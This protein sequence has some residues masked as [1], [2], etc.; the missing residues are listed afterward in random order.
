MDIRV[1]GKRA[2][3]LIDTGCTHSL[4]CKKVVEAK[5]I[6]Q[7]SKTILSADAKR[8]KIDGEV[9]VIVEINGNRLE[10]K[11][12]VIEKLVPG[13]D[14]IVGT[15]ILKYFRFELHYGKANI[16]ATGV[17][18]EPQKDVKEISRK[19]YKVS[20]NGKMWVAKWDWNETPR[21][22]NNIA[23]YKMKDTVSEAFQSEVQRWIENG[24][25]VESNSHFTGVV[26]LMAVV[27]ERKQKV[28]PVLDFRELNNFVNCSGVDADVCQEKLRKWRQ[29]PANC[30]MVDLRDAYMQIGVHPSCS[31][32]QIVSFN[33]KVYELKRLGFGLNCAPEIMKAIVSGVLTLDKKIAAATDHYYDD[34]IVNLD[35]VSV[36]DVIAFLKSNG[37]VCKPP[38]NIDESCVLGLQLYKVK[39]VLKWK[40]S[41][42]MD[43]NIE[44]FMSKRNVFSVCGKII[45]HYSVAGYLRVATSYIKRLCQGCTW[46]DFAG[47]EAIQK[48]KNLLDRLRRNDPVSGTWSVPTGGS[49]N[50][51]CDASKIAFGVVVEK[52]GEVVEDATWLRKEDDGSHINLAELNAIVKGTNLAL[53]WGAKELTVLTDSATVHSW[54]S[55]LLTK[56]R[57]IRV[58]GMSEMLV[59]RRLA[60][61]DETMESYSVVWSVKLISSQSNKADSLT[62]IPKEWLSR[63]THISSAVIP[64][65]SSSDHQKLLQTIT[66]IH[67]M[68]HRGIDVTQ[69][70][71]S[72]VIPNVTADAVKSVVERCDICKSVDPHPR[73]WDKGE[74]SVDHDWDR[75]ATD[76]THT[77]GDKK[78]L[79]VI[80]CGPS[81]FAIWREIQ[82]ET[83]TNVT[84]ELRQI[85]SEF[86]PPKQLLCDNG[87]SFRSKSMMDL[88]NSWGVELLFRCAYR[89]S[90]NGIIERHHR[91]IKVMSRRFQNPIQNCVFW[92]NITPRSDS[93]LIPSERLFARKW[94]NPFLN[95][96]ETE[97]EPATSPA[98]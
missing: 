57:K 46:D 34:I 31:K 83:D 17:S 38:E 28:R 86:G 88:C 25:L 18:S 24:W 26:P 19:N 96:L 63:N 44:E 77:N 39:E 21:L 69:Y 23:V 11:C 40:R 35:L 20:F 7:C 5:K 75:L 36:E 49:W 90:G 54:L 84:R 1:N 87:K 97:G 93:T 30:A 47:D 59:K 62:R 45:G 50:V 42:S 74:L 10:T 76:V 43:F 95:S 29:M 3:A 70:F 22:R 81:R 4:I 91:T 52:D 61:L 12:A 68:H 16:C 15:D 65:C 73:R 92:Y 85:F 56:D 55:S 37:L 60:V 58:S 8:M 2:K 6:G 13:I 48:L 64:D 9:D 78:F 32:F 80:D 94:H 89:P 67:N 27:Q 71:A 51:W 41:N 82:S 14:I 79:T 98:S 33:N 66:R 72:Q 53:K